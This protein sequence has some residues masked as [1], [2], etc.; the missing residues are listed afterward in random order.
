MLACET[1]DWVIDKLKAKVI[2]GGFTRRI[3]YVY[4]T[5]QGPKISFP[6]P[7][8][9]SAKL[10]EEMQEHLRKISKIV[11]QFKWSKEGKVF[12][13]QWYQELKS[14]EDDVMEGYY[15]SKQIQMLKVAMLV[16]LSSDEP[17]LVFELDDLQQAVAMLDAIEVNMPKLSVASGRN[18]LALPM[19]KVL[20]MIEK[21]GGVVNDQ[22]LRRMLG[23]D[24]GPAEQYIVIRAFIDGGDLSKVNVRNNGSI[25]L[26]Y[27]TKRK[28][29]DMKSKGEVL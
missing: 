29:A 9:N 27:A 26:L 2:S 1:P 23:K 4:E 22:T 17:K 5:D 24:F 11:G 16:A 12:Y 8:A 10:W 19:M 21:A 14:P 3:V 20:E 28:L 25:E 13:D 15:S 18:E 7:P 6:Q